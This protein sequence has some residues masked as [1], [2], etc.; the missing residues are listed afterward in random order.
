MGHCGGRWFQDVCNIHEDVQLW[1]EANHFL[2]VDSLPVREQYK[3][4]Y[5]F[6]MSQYKENPKKVLG[7]IKSFNQ[8]L[9][10]FCIEHNGSIFQM[11]R[12]PIA[13]IEAKNGHKIQECLSRG[14]FKEL[15]KEE[16]IFE[17]HVE[18][19]AYRFG[20]YLSNAYKWPLIKLEDLNYELRHNI[21]KFKETMKT[22]LG[23]SFTDE[24]IQIIR[25]LFNVKGD[26]SRA[27]AENN[28]DVLIFDS[29]SSW[30]KEIFLK[31]F[32]SIMKE[33]DYRWF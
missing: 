4:V 16:D 31:Y 32:K 12:N 13:I 19:Y 30:K 33:C 17:A 3:E 29:W 27:Y 2:N 14:V 5:D 20:H 25:D 23:V 11:F 24:H 22:I 10:D 15:K 28:R 8:E 18:F 9:I 21:S 1:Q 7:L 26:L 6:F